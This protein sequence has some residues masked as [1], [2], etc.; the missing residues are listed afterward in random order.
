L[1][2]LWFTIGAPF[3]IE[4]DKVIKANPGRNWISSLA[5]EI[6]KLENIE[7][8][9]AF[10]SYNK[11]PGIRNFGYKTI[12]LY[13]VS[14]ISKI[15]HK[16]RKIFFLKPELEKHLEYYRL[17]CDSCK[18]D[19]IHC[20]G[21]EYSYGLIAK[22]FAIPTLVHLQGILSEVQKKWFCDFPPKYQI[23]YSFPYLP[24]GNSFIQQ[25]CDLK[26]RAQIE[27]QI[28]ESNTHFGGR[29]AWDKRLVEKLANNYSYFR[30]NEIL[31]KEFY[32]GVWHKQNHATLKLISVLNGDIY[33]G[34]GVVAETLSLLMRKNIRCEWNIAGIDDKHQIFKMLKRK[35]KFDFE[36]MGLKLLGKLDAVKLKEH[37]LGSDIFIHP[38]Y[39]ENSSNSICEAM[40]L[41]LPVIATDVGG[42]GDLVQHERNGLLVDSGDAEA[43]LDSI[44]KLYMDPSL[45]LKLGQNARQAA[46]KR[47]DIN[48]IVANLLKTY[49]VMEEANNAK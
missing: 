48:A 31:R 3:S 10:L 17:V 4:Q 12:Q 43:L 8:S 27:K 34:W 47:H 26:K 29:T 44:N 33:K 15:D 49:S 25:Y 9:I 14:P 37:L 41:G 13:E 30:N 18:P 39:I 6:E 40:L 1:R 38:S 19:I 11:R 28:F 46:L 20:F 24:K 45:S 22:E 35:Y 2:V 32:D 7:L 23:L 5:M 42:T 16:L 36:K 21:T